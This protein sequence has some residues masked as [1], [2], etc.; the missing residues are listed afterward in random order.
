MYSLTETWNIP[1]LFSRDFWK[2]FDALSIE[3]FFW[4]EEESWSQGHMRIA[5]I[6]TSQAIPSL[7]H[8][9]EKN[10]EEKVLYYPWVD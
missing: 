9:R 7:C 3:F 6:I 2:M 8:L 5:A 10:V 1:Y 4:K